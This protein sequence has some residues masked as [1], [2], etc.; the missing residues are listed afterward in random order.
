MSA[1][2]IPVLRVTFAPIALYVQN[3]SQRQ[4]FQTVAVRLCARQHG[5][6][7]HFGQRI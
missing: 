3:G 2:A 7:E 5:G 6:R 1:I 4:G